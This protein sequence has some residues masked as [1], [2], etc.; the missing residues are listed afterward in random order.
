MNNLV[1]RAKIFA[2]KLLCPTLEKG[3]VDEIIDALVTE[4]GHCVQLM[5]ENYSRIV[6]ALS[7]NGLSLTNNYSP[8]QLIKLSDSQL[9][10][11]MK[12]HEQQQKRKLALENYQQLIN[13]KEEEGVDEEG[14]MLR[15]R[16]CS[17]T[18]ISW[19][20]RQ[21]RSADE[22]ATIFCTCKNCGTSWKT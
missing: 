21:M 18:D 4:S 16:T 20:S 14:G 10:N 2:Y 9:A 5:Q 17:N 6:F 22:P 15:C 11:G 8:S 7:E 1:E 12:F 19:V 13:R 3:L